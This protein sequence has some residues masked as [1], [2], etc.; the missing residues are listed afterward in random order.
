MSPDNTRIVL[1]G[2]CIPHFVCD[3]EDF[4]LLWQITEITSRPDQLTQQ[5]RS[6]KAERGDAKE[7]RDAPADGLTTEESQ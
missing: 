2:K 7:I 3:F 6:E 1:V 5:V 4:K